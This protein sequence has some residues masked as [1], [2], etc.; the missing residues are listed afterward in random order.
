MHRDLIQSERAPAAAGDYSQ[1]VRLREV[2]EWLI[3]SGQVPEDVDGVVPSDFGDQ[4]RRAWSNVIAQLE[5]ADMTVA[6]IVKV[7]TFLA[8]RA[9]A[10]ENRAVR[11]AIL[12]VHRPALTVVL[13]AIFDERWM[14]EIEVV[15]AR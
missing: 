11:T 9:F 4:C 13:T 3:V 6:D 12:G 1:A 5:A 2:T 7:T 8:S 10:A 15:A 14:L